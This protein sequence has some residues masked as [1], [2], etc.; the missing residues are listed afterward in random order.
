MSSKVVFITG[1]SRGIGLATAKKFATRGWHIAGFFNLRPGPQIK[2]VHWFQLEIADYQSIK[3]SFEQAHQELG[4]IDCFVNCVGVFGYKNLLEYDEELLDKV[5]AINERGAYLSTK[6]ILEKM[7]QGS[8]VY[9]SSTA[10]QVGSTDPV[11]A[12]TKSAM[13]GL[14]KSLA[15]ALAP[16][17]RV[18]CIAPGV[19]RSDMTSSMNPDRLKQL[20]DMTLLKRIAEPEDIANSIY[21]L[22]SDEAKHITGACLDINGGYVLR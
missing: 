19:T 8:I 17:I 2:N 21:F 14:T 1:A 9:I 15:K 7:D 18:N 11:Y 16:N 6:A 20:V 5:M 4:R 12:G 3:T 10:A 22:S 13:L